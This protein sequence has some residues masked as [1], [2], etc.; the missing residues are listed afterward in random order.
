MKR[1]LGL[2]VIMFLT[3]CAYSIS[4]IDV[5]NK[6]PICIRGCAN[7]Y[8]AC[9]SKSQ[10]GLKTETLRAC[11]ESYLICTNTCPQH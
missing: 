2:T 8:S 11:R 1:L 5:S 6:E 10:V 3:G 4:D 7:T 9:A